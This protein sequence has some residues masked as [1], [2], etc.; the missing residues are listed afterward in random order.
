V[1]S[2]QAD[3]TVKEEFGLLIILPEPGEVD[4]NKLREAWLPLLREGWCVAVVQS[5]NKE[6]WSSEEI[7]LAERV[8]ETVNDKRPIDIGRTVIAGQGV[9]GRLALIAARAAKGKVNG[10]LTLGTPLENA[11]L[12]R[13]N[14]PSDSMNFLMVGLPDSYA[15]LLKQLKESGY[16]AQGMG[17]SEL[18]PNKWD[19]LPIEGIVSWL[20]SIGRI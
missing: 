7:E 6:R 8:R 3:E 18:A 14:S 12:S 11:K 19:A 4:R 16:P 1:P 20:L 15:D 17:A 13:E 5:G 10:V 2:A 9:G